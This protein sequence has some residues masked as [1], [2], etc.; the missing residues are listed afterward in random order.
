MPDWINDDGTFTDNWMEEAGI[1]AE[2]RKYAKDIKDIKALVDRGYSTKQEFS[3]RIPVPEDEDGKRKVLQDHFQDILDADEAHRK[4]QAE[5]AQKEAAEKAKADRE[6][7]AQER[8]DQAE[9]ALKDQWGDDYDKNLELARR[10]FRRDDVPAMLVEAVAKAAGVEPKD[11]TDEQFGEIV[12]RDPFVANMLHYIG[13]LVQDGR[14]PTGDGH[15]G[16]KAEERKPV[17]PTCPEL[18][19]NYPDDHPEKQWF[20]NRGFNFAAMEWDGPPPR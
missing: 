13:T 1:P 5:A 19:K 7:T 14:L 2:Q 3:R 20:I 15:H 17:Q 18:Y 12:K 6:K 4:Q 8:L 16:D 9:K 10:A 11:V